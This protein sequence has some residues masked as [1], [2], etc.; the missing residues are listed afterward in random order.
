MFTWVP[1]HKEAVRKILEF[2]DPHHVPDT[3]VRRR[4]VAGLRNLFSVY[5]PAVDA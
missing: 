1:I 4:F 3:V 2:N 5:M